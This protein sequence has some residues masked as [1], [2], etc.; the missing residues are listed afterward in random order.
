M[1][2]IDN[3][4]LNLEYSPVSKTGLTWKISINGGR[5]IKIGDDAG[6][7]S[8]SGYYRTRIRGVAYQ[9]SRLIWMLFNGEIPDDL[10]IDHMD[11]NTKNNRIENLR[12]VDQGVNTRNRRTP[13]NNTSGIQ[14]ISLVNHRSGNKSWRAAYYSNDKKYSK[15]FPHSEEGL[16]Q[17][18]KWRLNKIIEIDNGYSDRH[19]AIE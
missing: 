11:G 4:K 2:F 18:I 17:A 5:G 8:T 7:L 14:G 1:D 10:V 12:L 16:Q 3:L 15:S 19:L 6:S 9:N 13:R